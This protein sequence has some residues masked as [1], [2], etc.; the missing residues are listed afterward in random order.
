MWPLCNRAGQTRRRQLLG[1]ALEFEFAILA[2]LHLFFLWVQDFQVPISV[3]T[4]SL[5]YPRWNDGVGPK[6][7]LA[8]SA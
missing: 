2:A 7:R 3:G 4:F 8:P 1:L 5:F 6:I